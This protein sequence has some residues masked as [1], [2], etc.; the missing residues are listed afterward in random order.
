MLDLRQCGFCHLKISKCAGS[1]PKVEQSVHTLS[2][3]NVY[4]AG[5]EHF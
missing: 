1:V 2:T 4:D 3:C 5:V